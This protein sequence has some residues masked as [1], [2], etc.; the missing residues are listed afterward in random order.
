MKHSILLFL[1]ILSV[2]AKAQ[3]CTNDDRFTEA[4]YFQ[5][6]EIDSI[7]NLEYARAN[8]FQDSLNI[9]LLDIYMPNQ[10]EDPLAK[11]P[12]V[13]QMF[14]GGFVAGNKNLMRGDCMALARKGFVCASINYRLGD[15]P[16]AIYRAQQ[17]AHAAMRWIV[18]NADKY[19]IDTS[20]L[21]VGGQ[22]AGAITAGYLQYAS[23]DDWNTAAPSTVD[24]LGRIDTS[25]NNLTTTFNIK[26]IIMNWGA[27][28]IDD[29][30]PAEMIPMIAFHGG[31]DPIVSIDST[32]LGSGGSRWLHN[33]LVAN[34]V[35]SDL[36]VAP[37]AGHSP[38]ILFPP[39]FRMSKASCFF[40]SLFCNDCNSVDVE[41][42]IPADCSSTITSTVNI[43]SVR[44][45]QVFPNP[46]E[47][48]INLNGLNG[49]ETLALFNSFGQMLFLGNDIS[50]ADLTKLPSGTYFLKI[51]QDSNSQII[52]LIK[53]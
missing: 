36:T 23:Q 5:D 3:F 18:A 41:Q 38:P 43:N 2:S 48:E 53:K 20:W 50:N 27:V 46:F 19:G 51:Q 7:L 17:D 1:L 44:E 35:C 45:I 16:R 9:L 12:F 40:K 31:E 26:G 11:R 14:G 13:L 8:D 28:R 29:V 25:G 22:S 34:D 21:V 39:S 49:N 32:A 37:E 47:K 33:V 24:S 15:V 10:S 6:N 30:S 4:D 52:K 42:V